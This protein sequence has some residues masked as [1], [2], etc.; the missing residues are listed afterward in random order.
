MIDV[1]LGGDWYD[2]DSA[3]SEPLN[4]NRKA[5]AA[6]ALWTE[7]AGGADFDDDGDIDGSDF[8]TWQRNHGTTAGATHE[9]G[10]ADGDEDVDDE[11]FAIWQQ[12]F[13]STG[14]AGAS[15]AFAPVPEPMTGVLG[16]LV[17][18]GYLC[19][20]RPKRNE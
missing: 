3:H 11:D 16:V 15:P 14:G 8:L 9:Q 12:D 20:R 19:L 1:G 17:A 13:G 10:D 2:C 18:L 6:W 4:A 5:Y 7:I